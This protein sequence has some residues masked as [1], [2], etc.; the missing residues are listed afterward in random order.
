MLNAYESELDPP[1]MT[2]FQLFLR[3]GNLL[4]A[5]DYPEQWPDDILAKELVDCAD[6][7]ETLAG[8]YD[9]LLEDYYRGQKETR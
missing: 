9:I 2:E 5:F 7:L 8:K 1:T 4:D 3:L 6:L